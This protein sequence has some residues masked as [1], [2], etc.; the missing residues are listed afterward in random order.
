M[1]CELPRILN[2]RRL[3]F[4]SFIQGCELFVHHGFINTIE[5]FLPTATCRRNLLCSLYQCTI[6]LGHSQGL[7]TKVGSGTP[8]GSDIKRLDE[9]VIG[10]RVRT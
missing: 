7:G 6:F 1:Y 8:P 4:S 9:G 3:E 10:W 2:Q 5:M